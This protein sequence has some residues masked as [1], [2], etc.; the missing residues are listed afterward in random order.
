MKNKILSVVV[1][2]YNEEETIAYS[3]KRLSE[4]LIN[5]K[6]SDFE[7]FELVYVNDG[8]ADNTATILNEIKKKN[9]IVKISIRIVHFSRNFGHSA[10]V[11]AGLE[12]A[13]GDHLVIIDADMQDPPEIIADMYLKSKDGYQVVYGKRKSRQK[14]TRFKLITAWLFYRILNLMTGVVIPNDTG[15]FRLITREVKEALLLCQ[16]PE[17][18]LRGLVAWLGFDQFA[19]EYDREERKFGSTKYPFKKMLRFALNAI[20]SFSTFPLK[21]AIYLS[22]LSFILCFGLIAWAL[23]MHFTGTTV[24]G[25][26]SIL[27]AFLFGQSMTLFVLGMVGFY[28]GKIHV[29][30]QGR[31]RFIVK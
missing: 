21:I 27:S 10:A 18:F 5:R 9:L 15:D 12:A 13:I 23:F 19:F 29:G 31:P 26:A 4:S 20:S 22:F 6:L 11:I 8:S 1:P 24:P 25:W 3:H 17:P 2:T 28:V 30:V 14:E 16:E 7:G